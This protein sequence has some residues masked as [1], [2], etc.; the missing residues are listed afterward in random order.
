[1][2][3]LPGFDDGFVL[4]ADT[5]DAAASKGWDDV[6]VLPGVGDEAARVLPILQPTG[7]H[8]GHFLTLDPAL[9]ALDG[10]R[11]SLDPWA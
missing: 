1:M 9:D 11:D 5:F 2:L 8:P 10:F 3:V 6:Q 4:P 7:D